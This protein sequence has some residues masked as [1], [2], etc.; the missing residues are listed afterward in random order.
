MAKRKRILDINESLREGRGTGSG[1]QYKPWIKIQDVPSLGRATRIRGKKTGRQHE[2]LS[3]LETNYFYI[4]EFSDEVVDIREQY[5]LLS[6]EDTI[7]IAKEI[8]NL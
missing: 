8:G 2:F 5:P 3:D 4:L 1:A 7:L 6:L